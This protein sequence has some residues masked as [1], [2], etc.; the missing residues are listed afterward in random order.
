M[1]DRPLPAAR[2][3]LPDR[4]SL[5]WLRGRAKR[6]Q[7]GVRDADPRA[8]DL[9]ETYDPPLGD[10]PFR[11]TRAQ[12]VL[13]RAFGFAGWSQLR[14]HLTVIETWSRSPEPEGAADE[15]VDRFLRLVCLTYSEPHG[16]GA[17]QLLRA[18][19][20]LATASAYAMAACGRADELAGALRDDPEV[21][22]RDGG[23]HDWPPLLYLCYSRLGLA[24]PAAAGDPVRTMEV[25]LDAGADP[26][27]GFLWHGLTSPFT[28][29]TGV[30]G[31]GERGE[32]PHPDGVRLAELLLAH[33]A[34][35][36]DNQALY[37][38]MF[39]PDDSHLGP[40]LAHGLGEEHPSVWRERLGS[41]YPNP[42]EMLGEH[43]R[44]AV[45]SGFIDR[46]RLLVAHGVDPN[47]VGYHPILGDQTAYEVAVRNGHREIATLLADAGGHSARLD[48]VDALL[49][50]ALSGDGDE[51]RRRVEADP[52][53]AERARNRRPEAMVVAAEHHGIA[54]CEALLALGFD[55][56]SSGRDGCTPL[57][58]AALDGNTELC[59]WLVAHGADRTLTD[60]RFDS[61]PKGWAEHG[62]HDDL[63]AEL[64]P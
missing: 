16:A 60:S 3:S 47:T 36:N 40:L 43:L 44:S 23:P 54:A 45:S 26:D 1:P 2:W 58:Q 11:L 6:L 7:R 22:R 29:L 61:P 8:L 52:T 4:P 37:N 53:L 46:V 50:T 41:A 15:P 55:V 32:P 27:S 28:A 24:D 63:A 35:P 25:L 51:V 62:G 59:R 21:V 12:R 33:G 48:D 39:E 42:Q 17:A 10:P 5:D 30:L 64:E 49:S 31:G 19:P 57:H 14:E 20:S 56:N 38:R 34:D 13:A 18:D 9:V